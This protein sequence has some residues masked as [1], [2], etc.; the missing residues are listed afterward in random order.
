MTTEKPTNRPQALDEFMAR[1]AKIA[2]ALESIKVSLIKLN[3]G[4]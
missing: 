1:V 3:D 2:D 4:T